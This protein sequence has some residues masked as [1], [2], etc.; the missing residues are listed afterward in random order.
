V[1]SSCNSADRRSTR[2][3]L[4]LERPQR[5]T[6]AQ[7]GVGGLG[8]EPSE[9]LLGDLVEGGE[10]CLAEHVVRRAAQGVLVA[11]DRVAQLG[12]R[13]AQDA[14]GAGGRGLRAVAPED[15]GQ[16]VLGGRGV[17]A[18]DAGELSGSTAA[19]AR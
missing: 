10:L 8:G 2:R 6:T 19:S 7:G 11:Q 1:T 5:E 12:R 14:A 3:V 16:D 18:V 9:E 4:A 13:R 17:Q 15:A